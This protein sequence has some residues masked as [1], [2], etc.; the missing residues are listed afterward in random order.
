MTW[1]TAEV[2]RISG[3]TSRTLR[4]YHRIG[5]LVPTSTGPGGVRHYGPA[6]LFRLQRVLIM[7]QLGMGLADIARVLDEKLGEADALR[8]HLEGLRAERDR[9]DG[10]AITVRRTLNALEGDNVSEYENH[11]EKLFEGLDMAAYSE[12]AR[13]RWPEQW[14]Q[15]RKATQG[16][17]DAQW[18]QTRAQTKAQMLRMG[19]HLTVGTPVTAPE[20]QAEVHAHY[21]AVSRMWTPDA[22]SY[23]NLG[24]T[25]AE[26]GGW[27]DAYESVVPGL[28]EYQRD[29]MAVYARER[30]APGTTGVQA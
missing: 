29:A 7:R 10:L 3:V 13:T 24:R 20:V 16:Y 26:E 4:H 30:L 19:A 12:Q 11:P 5:L 22:E 14:E 8:G 17:T 23:T 25:F 6:E 15:A 9:L 21:Q 27:R 1:P 2:C 18:E 28:A